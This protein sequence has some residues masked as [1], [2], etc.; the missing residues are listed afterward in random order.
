MCEDRNKHYYLKNGMNVKDVID[1]VI[2]D[3]KGSDAMDI[4][5]ALKYLLRC[6]KK[7]Q[8][9]SDIKKAIDFLKLVEER[10]ENEKTEN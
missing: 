1:E 10:Y 9:I 2:E 7:G 4:G 5:C 8:F 6:T 3:L